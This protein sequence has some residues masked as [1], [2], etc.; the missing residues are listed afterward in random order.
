METKIEQPTGNVRAN[1]VR[2]LPNDPRYQR[3]TRAERTQND[4]MPLFRGTISSPEEPDAMHEFAVWPYE[5]KEGKLFFA[6][7]VR[8][9]STRA[10]VEEHLEAARM[11]VEEA[12]KIDPDK[13]NPE[14]GEIES[15]PYE[16][17]PG[18]II[19]RVNNAKILMSD[20]AFIALD[21]AAADTNAKRPLYWLKWQ[22]DA[23]EKEVRGSLWDRS[24]RYG[25]FLSGNTQY[26]LS[27]EEAQALSA[28][29]TPASSSR[30][31]GGRRGQQEQEATELSR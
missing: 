7:P 23:G 25:P 3:M 1:F 14:T 4:R 29:D 18:T 5:G 30:K 6:G 11:S 28:T 17:N 9:L 8:L 15:Y 27:R 19:L 26:P 31:R 24:G 22:R 20:P 10:G 16:L 21:Q 2:V 12:A 13:V